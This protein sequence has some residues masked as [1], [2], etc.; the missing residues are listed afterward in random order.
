MN[1]FYIYADADAYLSTIFGS[2][3]R[4]ETWVPSLG[5]LSSLGETEREAAG[6]WG[7]DRQGSTCWS[8][9]KMM[10]VITLW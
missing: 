3:L 8:L 1:N 9:V 10:W 4:F 2:T 6:R 7:D 5:G